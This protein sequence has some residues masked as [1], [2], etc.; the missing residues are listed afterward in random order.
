MAGM[1]DNPP[2]ATDRWSAFAAAHALRTE[3]LL[4]D[5]QPPLSAVQN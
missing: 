2:D 3:R 5:R 4:W 1:A